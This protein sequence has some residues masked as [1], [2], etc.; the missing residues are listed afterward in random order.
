MKLTLLVW[1][2]PVTL[3][4]AGLIVLRYQLN[5]RSQDQRRGFEPVM[6]AKFD[7]SEAT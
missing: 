2:V 3:L 5:R 6:P 4:T 7:W 1:F